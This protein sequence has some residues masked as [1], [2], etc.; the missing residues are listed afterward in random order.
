MAILNT[1]ERI[2]AE[3]RVRE[4]LGV[5]MFGAYAREQGK[6]EPECSEALLRT[7]REILGAQIYAYGE[8]WSRP[9]LDLRT[10][11]FITIAALGALT[12]SEQLAV[13]VHAALNLGIAPED[14]LEALMQMGVY[15]GLSAASIGMDVARDVFTARGLR[16]P[17]KGAEMSPL[18]P[19]TLEQRNEAFMRVTRD[20]SVARHGHDPDAAPLRPLQTGPWAIAADDLPLEREEINMIQGA[21]GYGE[22][23]GRPALGYRIRSFITMATLQATNEN[24][25]LHFHINN[26][27]NLQISAEEVHEAMMQVGVYCGVSGW[28]NAANVARD[29]F[30][31]R[32]IVKPAP[33]SAWGRELEL[34][35]TGES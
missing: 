3:K 10:R 27:I 16:K 23:W 2:D 18:I 17:G 19:M 33:D 1:Q 31:Q 32:G 12:R 26:A 14:V 29:I 35:G 8:V 20:L 6:A 25:Q 21:Y 13:Y 30:L 24:D 15:A 9:T 11:C 5:P 28:R 34:T 7:E 4:A 22:I